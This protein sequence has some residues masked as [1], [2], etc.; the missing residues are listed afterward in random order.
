MDGNDVAAIW[1]RGGGAGV[2]GAAWRRNS[3]MTSRS[4]APSAQRRPRRRTP[5]RRRTLKIPIDM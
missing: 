1:Q 3:A 2:A 4:T 5:C